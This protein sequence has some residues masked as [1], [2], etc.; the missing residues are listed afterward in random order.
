MISKII[1]TGFSQRFLYS[2]VPVVS[3]SDPVTLTAKKMRE[4]QVNSVV[5]MTGNMLLGIFTY[6]SFLQKNLCY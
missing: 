5:V 6:V 1:L 2:S 4:H 3:P